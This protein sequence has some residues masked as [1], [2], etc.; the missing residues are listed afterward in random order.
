M[1]ARLS[2]A[3]IATAVPMGAQAYQRQIVNRAAPAFRRAAPGPVIVRELTIRSLRSTLAGNRR[4]PL[5]HVAKAGTRERRLIGRMLYGHDAVTH[6]MSLE[7]PPSPHGDVVTLHDVVAWRFPDESA[8]VPSAI[9]ELRR[10]DAVI[11]V[12]EF[13]AREASDLL[14]IRDVH[15]VHNGVDDRYFDAEPLGPMALRALGIDRAFV[16]HAGGAALRKNLD[17][18][19]AA[20]PLI[21]RER[22]DLVLAL[23]GPPHPHRTALF[24]GMPGVRMLGRL[25]DELM[26]GIVAAASAL[27]VPSLYE[28]FGLPVL[29]GFAANVPV[30]AA[31]TSSLPEVAGSSAILVEPDA[32]AIASGVI[33][34][35]SGDSSLNSMVRAARARAAEFTWERCVTRHAKIWAGLL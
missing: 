12:S 29:E 7:L 25:D 13:S 26:P 3:T 23:A 19:A 31:N 18:L 34:A 33:D 35:T 11:C 17:A 20:W 32:A 8:P 4:I 14:G 30:V 28:G 21:R 2:I 22:P 16:L 10:A 6:R 9:D 1:T 5:A 15:V 27:V 24:G